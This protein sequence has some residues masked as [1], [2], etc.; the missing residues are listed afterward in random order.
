MSLGTYISYV[1]IYSNCVFKFFSYTDFLPSLRFYLHKGRAKV[2]ILWVQTF[3]VYMAWNRKWY[4][5]CTH[6]KM[7]LETKKGS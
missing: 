6:W 7:R 5:G 4:P 3:V 2:R 1:D